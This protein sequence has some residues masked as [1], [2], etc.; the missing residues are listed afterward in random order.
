MRVVAALLIA[1]LL[2]LAAPAMATES[3]PL[4]AQQAIDP[5]QDL[6]Q[7][8]VESV[9]QNATLDAMLVTITDQLQQQQ[10]LLKQIEEARPGL[11]VKLRAAI[12]PVMADYWQRARVLY[13]PKFIAMMHD[14]LTADEARQLAGFYR[15]PATRALLKR[16]SANY[17]GEAVIGGVMKD[18]SAPVAASAVKSDIQDAAL[19]GL[20]SMSPEELNRF[21]D[22]AEATPAI[23]KLGK[24]N[25]RIAQLRVEMEE[26][27]MTPD[28]EQRLTA[29]VQD[30]I[31][32]HLASD[33][34]PAPA[35][36]D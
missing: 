16:A 12:K 27:P 7:A 10:P 9:D 21:A 22:L 19:R 8:M 33:S 6:Y 13:Q 35:S 26:T 1:P 15:S 20:S 30:T 23:L 17:T 5:H 28:E 36:A 25:E 29:A 3:A 14:E 34:A 32:Q 18:P 2:A 11:M 4:A 24:V 31:T